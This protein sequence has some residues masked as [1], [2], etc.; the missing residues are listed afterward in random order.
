MSK[1][2]KEKKVREKRVVTL[3][4][5]LSICFVLLGLFLFGSLAGDLPASIMMLLSAVYAIF[6]GW[7]CGY[8]FKELEEHV[9]EK[10][11]TA[12]PVL[13]V[14]LAVGCLLSS[15]MYSGTLPMF[16]YYGI[17]FVSEQWI[18]VSG[19]LL[20]A[21]FS[22][23]TGTSWGSAAT[24][25][26]TV[27]GIASGMPDVNIPAVAAA[28]YTGAIFGDKLSPLSD[29][30]ILAA[31]STKNDIFDHIKHMSKTVIPAGLLGMI[32][33]IIMGMN[34]ESSNSE[35][36]ADTL[37]LL[38]TLDTVFNWNV[39]VL[40]PIAIVIFGSITKKPSS[41]VMIASSIAAII[42]GTLYQGFG[43]VDAFSV[44]WSGFDLT[45]AEESVKGFVAAD[46]GE[47]ALNLLN[48][49]GMFSMADALVL[50][51]LAYYVAGILEKIGGITV[52]L[53]K[54]FDSVKTRLGLIISTA[55]SC[56]V[57]VAVGGG[58][59]LALLMVGELYSE[60]YKKMGLSTLNLSRTMEDFCTGFA[61]FVPWTSS[62][63]YYAAIFGMPVL[64]FAQ[65]AFM[66]YFIW[67]LA[68]FYA[69]T[70]FC[71]KKLK[72]EEA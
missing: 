72:E 7:R 34:T 1:E 14:L 33:Y 17:T 47:N 56:V 10:I 41:L 9:S 63:V 25:G 15:W 60:K 65:Y 50:I 36:P 58:S 46:A 38:D 4:E 26:V 48:R 27:M 39:I 19:F 5:A 22:T 45:L 67:I 71:I 32:I 24:A 55:I 2:K 43:F 69:A 62:A 20:C 6:I 64:A 16:I 70:G 11:K 59:S 35:L 44:L 57:L 29:T 8:S 54:M 13:T 42:I 21:I 68:I 52:L 31:L 53:G 51:Y 66:S 49:G 23:C 18:I 30:T 28:C 40:I 37:Q 61:G 3:F 12:V